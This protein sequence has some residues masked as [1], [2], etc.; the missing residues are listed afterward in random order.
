MSS[1]MNPHFISLVM[2][3]ASQ[4]DAALQGE[5]PPGAEEAGASDA[6]QLAQSL[7]DTLGVL[8]LK[9]R[10]NLE[11]EE[12]RLLEGAL[13]TLRFKFVTGSPTG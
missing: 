4:A 9:T 11:P 2:G 1:A 7:I 12:A 6:R 13:T 10:G 8:E 5:L 3:L